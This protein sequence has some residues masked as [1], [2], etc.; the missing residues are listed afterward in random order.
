MV[1]PKIH[2]EGVPMQPI[3]SSIGSCGYNVAKFLVPFLQPLTIH[4]YTVK[5]SFSLNFVD[6]NSHKTMASFDIKSL[7]TNEP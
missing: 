4:N 7:F 2:K 3:F 1:L 5:D 6:T